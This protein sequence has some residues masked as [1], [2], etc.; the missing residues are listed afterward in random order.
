MNLK[1]RLRQYN[2]ANR[3]RGIDP[4]LRALRLCVKLCGIF[5]NL[6]QRRKAHNGNSRDYGAGAFSSIAISSTMKIKVALGGIGPRPLS[7]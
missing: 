2:L 4:S 6:R 5:G 3:G 1:V 7:P